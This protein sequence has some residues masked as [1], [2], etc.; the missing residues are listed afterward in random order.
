MLQND[1]RAADNVVEAI[2]YKSKKNLT[3]RKKDGNL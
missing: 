1:V 3:M 2:Q